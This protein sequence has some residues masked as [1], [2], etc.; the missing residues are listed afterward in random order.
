MSKRIVI[1][2]VVIT[3]IF[4]AVY[5]ILSYYAVRILQ[6]QVQKNLPPGVTFSTLKLT[7]THVSLIDISIVDP[8]GRLSLAKIGTMKIFPAIRTLFFSER[9]IIN[10]IIMDN[11]GIFTYKNKQ[12]RFLGPWIVA[13]APKRREKSKPLNITI[14]SII[15]NN[16]TLLFTDFQTQPSNA[17]IQLT[18]L[19]TSIQNINLPDDSSKITF[20]S[21]GKIEKSKDASVKIEG[22]YI[23]KNNEISIK[24]EINNADIHIFEPYYKKTLGNSIERGNT[25]LLA[26][27]N[28]FKNKLIAD[29][30]IT[31]SEL[32]LN[33]SSIYSSLFALK[34]LPSILKENNNKLESDFRVEGNLND[35]DFK[36][37][38]E[39]VESIVLNMAKKYQFSLE[40]KGSDI[41]KDKAK[42]GIDS[43]GKKLDSL[44]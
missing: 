29:G 5:F 43:L 11:A 37:S 13:P 8:A 41:I 3:L 9:I 38:D 7:R 1:I 23:S 12:G 20:S 16:G 17:K 2:L 39:I 40:K 18:D 10:K 44:F 30:T 35:P 21:K 26:E 25:S 14:Q 24:N 27:I 15:T 36:L 34:D 22:W 28:I 32:F 6:D 4:V 19:Q 33:Q 31:L 42:K